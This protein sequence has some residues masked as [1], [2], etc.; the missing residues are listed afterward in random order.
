VSDTPP[1]WPNVAFVD[2]AVEGGIARELL[3]RGAVGE[4]SALPC[5]LTIGTGLIRRPVQMNGG[6]RVRLS[7]IFLFAYACHPPGTWG[8][9]PA[10][11]KTA[12]CRHMSGIAHL[13]M[14]AFFNVGVADELTQLD[15]PGGGAFDKCNLIP[16]SRR[17]TR[18]PGAP[19]CGNEIWGAVGVRQQVHGSLQIEITIAQTIPSAQCPATS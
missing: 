5:E 13:L 12:I 18:S 8:L 16:R 9:R 1:A 11:C 6:G 4:P 3:L 14:P 10:F 17:R 19:S 7:I 15:C 2:P